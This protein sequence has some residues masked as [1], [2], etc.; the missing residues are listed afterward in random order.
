M[1]YFVRTPGSPAVIGP[2][3]VGEIEA[4]LKAGELSANALATEDT[5]D[6]PANATGWLCLH[7]LPGVGGNPPMP[8]LDTQSATPPDSSQK[9]SAEVAPG[10]PVCRKCSARVLPGET[11]CRKC[12]ERTEP[13]EKASVAPHPLRMLLLHVPGG[14]LVHLMS[15]VFVGPFLGYFIIMCFIFVRGSSGG[16]LKGLFRNLPV[17]FHWLG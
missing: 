3:S 17:I 14:I 5:G 2:Y 12:A 7:Q 11:L 8:S 6:N 13:A 10:E 4:R 15:F 16:A 9:L 1:K